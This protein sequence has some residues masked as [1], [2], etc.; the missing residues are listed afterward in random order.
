MAHNLARRLDGTYMALYVGQPAWTSVGVVLDKLQTPE[1]IQRKVFDR[2]VIEAFPAYAKIGK[3][4]VEVPEFRAIGDKAAGKVFSFASEEYVPIQD[5]DA[6]RVA[7]QIVKSNRKAIFASAGLLGNGARGFASIDLTRVLGADALAITGDPSAQEAFLFADWAHDGS[8]SVKYGRWRNRVDCNNMLDAANAAAGKS[9]RLARILHRGGA[10]SMA[11]QVREAER[12][13]GF[14]VAD[15]KLNTKLLNELAAISLPKPDQWFADFTEKLVPIP[16]D[17][18]RK[19]TREQTRD[20][21][22]DL[23]SGSKTLQ[24]VPKTP[25]RGLQVVTEYADHF[26]PL[27]ISEANAASVPEKRFRSIVEGPAADMKAFALELIR[28][29]F[30]I[31]QKVPVK[32]R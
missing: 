27:R 5:I 24:T 6:L 16:D 28:Q 25:Y 12:V 1:Q 23:W 30:E 4:V 22:R 21:L 11:D 13:L 2:R 8:G 29:E 19:S 10:D 32:A 7:G 31:G 3:K 9:G 18:E 15:M 26:R 14:T 20:L 17:M